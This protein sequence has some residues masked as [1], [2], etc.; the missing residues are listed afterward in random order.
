M[1]LN[2]NISD[3][4]GAG[5]T[6]LNSPA[7]PS[8]EEKVLNAFSIKC[9]SLDDFDFEIDEEWN[10]EG[11]D[12]MFDDE[13]G[14]WED[15]DENWEDEFNFDEEEDDFDDEDFDLDGEFDLDELD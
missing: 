11:E 15:F 4:I 7:E 13:D 6:T 9:D 12:G 10:G 14:E 5:F 1:L 2:Y 3:T 8:I